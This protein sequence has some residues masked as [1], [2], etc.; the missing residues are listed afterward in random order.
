VIDSLLEVIA[1]HGPGTTKRQ[2]F[3]ALRVAEAKR[4]LTFEYCLLASGSSHN[5]APSEQACGANRRWT[6]Y[7]FA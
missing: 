1:H 3:D 4:G 6:H 7:S 5:R 2:L